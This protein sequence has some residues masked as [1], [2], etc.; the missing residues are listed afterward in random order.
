VKTDLVET[1]Q[2]VHLVMVLQ[3]QFPLAVVEDT[4]A[5][6]AVHLQ[7]QLAMDRQAEAVATLEEQAHVTLRLTELEAVEVHT[8][9]QARQVLQLLL[10]YL[11]VYQRLMAL[12]LQTLPLST[13]AKA[14][15][16]YR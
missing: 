10:D 16:L 14:Q 12:Q 5:L 6:V 2:E 15:L 8:L 3:Q 9:S 7:K 11:M 13:T 4:A 1:Q